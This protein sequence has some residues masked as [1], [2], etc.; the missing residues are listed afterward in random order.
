[1]FKGQGANQ[2]LCDGPLLASWLSSGV[3]SDNSNNMEKKSK[4]RKNNP[5]PNPN[6]NPNTDISTNSINNVSMDKSNER[7]SV[8]LTEQNVYTRLRCFEREMVARTSSKVMASRQAAG[9]LHSPAVLLDNFGI[10]G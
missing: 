1:M 9:H 8:E 3:S 10:E 6:P 4:I 5:N 7:T 2:A